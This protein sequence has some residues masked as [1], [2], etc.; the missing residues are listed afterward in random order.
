MLSCPL[1]LPM[2][3]RRFL[4][5]V[6][7]LGVIAAIA[8]W[9]FRESIADAVRP[10]RFQF[11]LQQSE[12]SM[13]LGDTLGA[14]RSARQAWQLQPNDFASLHRL[15]M[16]DRELGLGDLAEITIL[17]FHHPESDVSTQQE[18]LRWVLDRGDTATFAD[19]HQN[20]GEQ[21][22]EVPEI[23]LL[24]AESLARQSRLLEAVEEARAIADVP[25][26]AEEASL[27]LTSLLPRLE[28]NPLAWEQARERIARLLQ[29]EDSDRALKAWRNLR[30][31]PQEFR[32]PGTQIPVQD[33]LSRQP[34]ATAEDR[35]LARQIELAR[36]PAA[37]RQAFFD[38][39]VTEFAGDPLATPALARWLL[40]IN[41]PNRL[42]DL[43]SEPMV[44]DLGL[45]SARLQAYI[46]TG[47]LPEAE[48][49]LE[50]PHPQISAVLVTS[51]KAAFASKAGR[52]PEAASLWE[53][54]LDQAR[55][56]EK[57]A[58]CVS[59]LSIAD[60]FRENEISTRAIEVM[61]K[62]PA[63]E[64]PPSQN[65]EFLEHRL[66]DRFELLRRFWEDLL[67]FRPTDPI[68]VEQAAFFQAIAADG[69]TPS[70]NSQLTA[71]L[72]EDYPKI[73]RFRTTHAL[74]LMR[75]AKDSEAAELLR[76]APVNWNQAADWDRAVYTLALY[77]AGNIRDAQALEQGLR[78]DRMS[79]LRREALSRLSKV[80]GSTFL[81][82]TP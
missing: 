21:R 63:N 57:F 14:Q 15:M 42:L 1:P 20:M 54:A 2:P 45:Y 3:L 11:L 52:R 46:D 17:V 72:V 13:R 58:D 66:G 18:I 78:V 35:L 29:G 34:G 37:E 5:V 69:A 19:L 23:R 48:A 16:H 25:A 80:P 41:M 51:L 71:P 55:S 9:F 30:L 53:Q 75:E 61:L 50:T 24:M 26:V 8:V 27:L 32:D 64:L 82:A 70:A 31:L 65:L 49:W 68:T 79:P 47:R 67:R 10:F 81:L 44:S 56:F 33:W 60:R 76:Q 12:R 7:P 22:S 36:L 6:L 40:E 28:S 74:W 43:P 4:L 59:I 39:I 62:L 77:R 38:K 73:L